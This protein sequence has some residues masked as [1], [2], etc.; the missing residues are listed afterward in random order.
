MWW[1]W[2]LAD[3]CPA[4]SSRS[5]CLN[6]LWTFIS[7][8]QIFLLWFRSASWNKA[9]MNLEARNPAQF[10]TLLLFTSLVPVFHYNLPDSST[11]WASNFL[12]CMHGLIHWTPQNVILE[13]EP[14]TQILW[15]S[16]FLES[17]TELALFLPPCGRG[18]R[19]GEE[20]WEAANTERFLSSIS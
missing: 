9:I 5:C 12:E 13:S 19:H 11:L 15:V 4:L 8:H 1:S 6:W 14:K 20:S 2:Q 3:K 18:G 17:L 10:T 16:F 7:S